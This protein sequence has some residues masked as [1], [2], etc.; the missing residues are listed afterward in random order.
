MSK[1]KIFV[2]ACLGYM[3]GSF[4]CQQMLGHFGWTG[5]IIGTIAI[6]LLAIWAFRSKK[7]GA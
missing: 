2:L 4:L 7:E 5:W 6:A 1:K 3:T